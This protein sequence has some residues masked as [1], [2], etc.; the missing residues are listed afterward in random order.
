[1]KKFFISLCLLLIST[2][3][4]AD[5]T[6]SN[7]TIVG[8]IETIHIKELNSNYQARIDTGAAT[9][10]IHATNIKIV[11]TDEESDNMRDHLGDTI[12][13][14]TYNENGDASEHTGRI[15]RVSKIRNAQGVERRY[16]VRMHL[17][18]DGKEKKIA[19]NL[20]DR[21]KLDYKLLIGRNWLEGDY[22]VDVE[23]NAE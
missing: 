3:S 7:K 13:F 6:C 5:E 18:F 10:S 23:K 4:F 22:L 12:K 11:G 8:Q 19:V 16:A 20:R 14:T 2:S 1:M 9:T 21:S 15:I 17:E